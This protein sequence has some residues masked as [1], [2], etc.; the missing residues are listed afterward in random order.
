MMTSK[1]LVSFL[2]SWS[3][4]LRAMAALS[5]PKTTDSTT[6]TSR[7][8]V[9][10]L[11][12]CPRAVLTVAHRLHHRIPVPWPPFALFLFAFLVSSFHQNLNVEF[13]DYVLYL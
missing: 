5:R 11:L 3:F 1:S 10:L 12:S 6:S 8:R 2:V 9:A 7:L 4:A 13:Y